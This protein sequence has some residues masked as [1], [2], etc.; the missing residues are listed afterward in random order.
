M[1]I[2]ISL[3]PYATLRENPAFD[4]YSG[5]FSMLNMVT[6]EELPDSASRAGGKIVKET[7]TQ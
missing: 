3:Y 2:N 6:K 5:K 1:Y 4:Q 7:P